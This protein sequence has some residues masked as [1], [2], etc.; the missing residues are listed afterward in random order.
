MWWAYSSYFF[1]LSTKYALVAIFQ[2]L[3]FYSSTKQRMRK[4]ERITQHLFLSTRVSKRVAEAILN[5]IWDPFH[6]EA[7]KIAKTWQKKKGTEKEVQRLLVSI[8]PD[9]ISKMNAR[10]K[11]LECV[12]IYFNIFV[13]CSY[14]EESFDRGVYD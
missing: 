12:T 14:A 13:C 1:N 10:D 7:L 11:L 8:Y 4:S 6:A 2:D 5:D 9:N 3:D